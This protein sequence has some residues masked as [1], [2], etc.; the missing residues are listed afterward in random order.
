MPVSIKGRDDSRERLIQTLLDWAMKAMQLSIV[1]SGLLIG[2]IV[3]G[4]LVGGGAQWTSLSPADQKRIAENI[5]G[6]LFYLNFSLGVLLISICTLY[7]DEEPTGYALVI[8]SV[9]LYYGVP[10]LVDMAM[11]GQLAAWDRSYNVVAL[12]VYNEFRL[13]GLV[14]AI[15]GAV[16]MI[17]DLALRV[18]DGSR[19]EREK[20]TAMQYGGSVKEEEDVVGG[21]PVGLF[22]KC[23]QLPFCRAAI[24]TNCPIFI[25]K[26]RCWRERVGCMCE[27]N[28]IR[29]AM[30]VVLHREEADP[31]VRKETNEDP[32]GAGLPEDEKAEE[33]DPERTVRIP[34]RA[35]AAAQGK[36]VRIPHN[37]NLPMAAKRERCRNCVIYN[38][39]QRL[40]YQFFAPLFVLLVPGLT[41]LKIN[42]VVATIGGLL[43][44]VDSVMSRLSLDPGAKNLGLAASIPPGAQYVIIGCLVII[45]TTMVLRSLEYTI[46]KLKI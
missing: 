15:P 5:Q 25:H 20:F 43:H 35:R 34:P 23:W 22:A 4:L 8:S 46:F 3:Y 11:P 17:R 13:V 19:R 21:A 32:L 38:E 1:V 10:L 28:V 6:S 12:A 42:E 30:D 41:F 40:K 2:Y 33:L 29:H 26:T 14:I 9:L 24:R 31:L 18:M 27:E 36:K 45:A 16:L 7:Y 44:S 39:H 37:P